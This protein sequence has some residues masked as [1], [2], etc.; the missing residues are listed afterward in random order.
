MTTLDLDRL[1]SDE[2][3]ASFHDSEL[4]SL[5]LDWIERSAHL[6]FRIPVSYREGRYPTYRLGTLHITGLVFLSMEPPRNIDTTQPM[7]IAADGPLPDPNIK[8]E[9]P[10]PPGIPDTAFLHY[11]FNTSTNSFLYFA[12]QDAVFLWDIAS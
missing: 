11:I 5:A 9:L 12:G 1:L 10:V 2:P 4:L 8:V 3:D 7:W 6:R